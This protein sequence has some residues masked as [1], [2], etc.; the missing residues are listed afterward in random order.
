MDRQLTEKFSPFAVLAFSI[1][2]AIGWGSLVVTTS[3][4]LGAGGPMG[5][6]LGLIIGGVA[7]MLVAK[8]ISFMIQAFPGIGGPYSYAKEVFGYDHGFLIAWFMALTYLTVLWANVT[9]IPLF[10]R[11][12]VGGIFQYGY[13]Y[14]IFG[15]DIY[16]GELLIT[17]ALLIVFALICMYSSKLTINLMKALAAVFT[18]I[19]IA[20]FLCSLKGAGNFTNPAFL[21]GDENRLNQI[22]STTSMTPWAFIGFESVALFSYEF[23]FKRTK[24]SRVLYIAVA[25]VTLLYACIILLSV[26]AYPPQYESWAEYIQNT[27]SLSGIGRFPA[28]YAAKAHL[29]N[30]GVNLLMLALLAL[31]F[32]SFIGN[33]VAL[34]RLFYA[35]SVDRVLPAKLSELNKK[36][37]PA[38]T[39]FLTLVISVVVPFLGRTTIGWIV[40]VTTIG[41]TI[42]Y[43]FI[44]A[45]ALKIAN[46]RGDKGQKWASI[47][48]LA[49]ILLVA[50]H[51]LIPALFSESSF[52]TETYFLFIV[53]TILGFIAFRLLLTR[54]QENRF[55]KSVI[56]WIALLSLVLMVALIWMSQSMIQA[57][58]RVLGTIRDHYIGTLT[59]IRAADEAFI[60]RQMA[61][62]SKA[63]TRTVLAATAMFGLYL[64]FMMSNQMFINKKASENAKIANVDPLTGTKSRHA[65][66]KAEQNLNTGIEENKAEPFALVVCDINGLK[67]VNDTYGHKAGDDYIRAASKLICTLFKHSPVYR[68]GGDEFVVIL[69]GRDYENRQAHM[70][71]LGRISAENRGTRKPVIAAGI[72]DYMEKDSTANAVFERADKLMYENKKALKT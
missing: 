30:A 58:S 38:K 24:V 25:A 70:E 14:T 33:F 53:W 29:G 3:D 2:T 17:I 19:I 68:T 12:F 55:G 52:A 35:L 57:N 64:V 11:Y 7:M 67:Q 69:T 62:L 20:V 8:N 72:S 10:T 28:F 13:L 6:V 9:S 23:T 40:D 37:V 32:S 59:H 66:L 36:G 43:G 48:S 5:S 44:G 27:G 54:D 42:I 21:P 61:E 15:Y 26:T 63:N 65:Y 51:L 22:I 60:E 71:E 56:V 39:Y 34:S 1:G 16:F 50:G 46:D 49:I 31:V 47:I 41:A 18:V 45:C 4:Y